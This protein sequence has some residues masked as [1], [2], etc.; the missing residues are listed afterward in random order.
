M[1][2]VR[3]FYYL[4]NEIKCIVKKS[5]KEEFTVRIDFYFQTNLIYHIYTNFDFTKY[6]F[7]LDSHGYE[8][9]WNLNIG[10]DQNIFSLTYPE[11]E[12]YGTKKLL[13][14]HPYLKIGKYFS[15][16]NNYAQTQFLSL[17][18]HPEITKFRNQHEKYLQ[19]N[20]IKYLHTHTHT[21]LCMLRV[22]RSL[23]SGLLF[24]AALLGVFWFAPSS[25]HMIPIFGRCRH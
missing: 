12:Q 21:N 3:F 4:P 10:N 6:I 22:S 25:L 5:K 7:L 19:K 24:V 17:F 14:D 13:P 15:S 11:I 23:A 16:L 8:L 2:Y 20:I 1:Q 9:K 18:I